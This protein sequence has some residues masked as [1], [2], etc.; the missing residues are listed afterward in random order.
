[1]AVDFSRR[2]EDVSYPDTVCRAKPPQIDGLEKP[3]FVVGLPRTG[4][5]LAMNIISQ[6]RELGYHI[7][8]EIHFFGHSRLGKIF[9]GRYGVEG[10]VKKKTGRTGTTD[11]GSVV[12]TLYSQEGALGVYWWRLGNGLDR[13]SK[14]KLIAA[15]EKTRGDPRSIY[16]ALLSTQEKTY[17][18]YGDK[19]G[20]NL[21]HVDRLVEWF[22]DCRI[23][24]TM[25]DPR[26]ILASQHKKHLIAFDKKSDTRKP[27]LLRTLKRGSLSLLMV[28]YILSYWSHAI[29][30][31][32]RYSSKYP[33]KYIMIRF[34]D[35]V[36]DPKMVVS[37]LC[38]FLDCPVDDEM[39][40]PPKLGSSYE[41]DKGDRGV[42]F[43]T[44]T[45]DRWQGYLRPWM[46]GMVRVWWLLGG[47]V[48]MRR[49]GYEF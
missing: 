25:R 10:V 19:S 45:L 17:R 13:L 27:N 47:G 46:K 18:G 28:V 4:T 34:E 2:R 11:W 48:Q 43:D 24:H 42:G 8:N 32:R 15:L 5:K 41:D 9:L 16:C 23:V 14:E 26:A 37:R 7:S 1:M 12:D 38:S 21:Y 22:P 36:Q 44:Q 35:L 40:Q 31:H 30:L 29:R 39:V 3:I 20:P 49:E 33:K 6:N